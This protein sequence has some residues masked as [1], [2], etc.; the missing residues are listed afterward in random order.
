V[1]GKL[2]APAADDE[3]R[4]L[5][6]DARTRDRAV[7]IVTTP[8]EFGE[9]VKLS[10]AVHRLVAR[11]AGMSMDSVSHWA[12]C[13]VDRGAGPSYCYDLMSDQL[14]LN[15]LGNNYF[16]AYGV[17]VEAVGRWNSCFYVGET[18]RSHEEIQQVG[19]CFF[20]FYW[21]PSSGCR[22]GLGGL[23]TFLSNRRGV[24][25]LEAEI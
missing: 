3:C 23:L 1:A 25:E 15:T 8:I 18:R 2:N 20:P 11:H 22:F 19:E 17:D 13:V 21:A 16:R 7:F 5:A 12:L 14:A 24:L 9:R 6:F 4:S 10:H